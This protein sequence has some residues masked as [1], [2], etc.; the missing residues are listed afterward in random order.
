MKLISTLLVVLLLASCSKKEAV[1]SNTQNTSVE[2][3]Q[4]I[5]AAIN[6]SSIY[7]L[8]FSSTDVEIHQQASHF[9]LSAIGVSAKNGMTVY[10]YL[11]EKG[12]TGTDEVTIKETKS[13][14]GEGGGCRN[15]SGMQSTTK[16][17]YTKIKFSVAN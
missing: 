10:Q 2:A 15:S 11:P 7:E 9:T 8:P 4:V 17:S 6:P 13:Y 5:N 14:N 3:A 1:I 16:I 12:F